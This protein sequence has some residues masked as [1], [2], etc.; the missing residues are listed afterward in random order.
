[1]AKEQYIERHNT[2][3]PHLHFD[4]HKEIWVKLNNKQWYEHVLE[5]VT[6]ILEGKVTILWKQHVQTNRTDPNNKPGIILRGNKEGTCMLVDRNIIKREAEK[7][8]NRRSAHVDCK[9]R[10]NRGNWNH[11]NTIQTIPKQHTVKAR[12]KGTTEN[13]HIGHFP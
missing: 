4:S 12:N 1:L 3:C 2:V 10:N 6:T 11:I 8:L 7:F 9:I 13:S 5:S